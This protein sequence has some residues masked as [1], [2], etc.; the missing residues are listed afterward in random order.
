MKRPPRIPAKPPTKTRALD[1]R[2]L[3][4]IRGGGGLG[5]A[6]S[7]PDTTPSVMTQQH[8]EELISL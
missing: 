3:H 1:T 5:I 8:N 6:V 4:R 7:V 2:R